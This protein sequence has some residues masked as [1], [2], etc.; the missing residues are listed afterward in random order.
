MGAEAEI[1]RLIVLG[2]RWVQVLVGWASSGP[3]GL[4]GIV[5]GWGGNNKRT[6][7]EGITSY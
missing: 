7:M 5:C 4:Q 3:W 2:L 6:L 1:I